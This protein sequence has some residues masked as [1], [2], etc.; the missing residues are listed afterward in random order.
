MEPS[1]AYF[2]RKAWEAAL[3]EDMLGHFAAE[4]APPD[5]PVNQFAVAVLF[6]DLAIFTPLTEAMGDVAAAAVIQLFADMVREEAAFGS[7][8]VVKQIGDE[9]MLV[10]PTA[11][12]ALRF[13]LRLALRAASTP[14]FPSLR[15]GANFG[16]AL[17]R[18]ADYLGATVNI[19]A[20]V[21]AVAQAGELVVTGDFRE[22]V[23]DARVTFEERGPHALKG[24]AEPVE[25]HRLDL[26][27]R[28][29]ERSDPVCGMRLDAAETVLSASSG[30]TRYE[31]CSEACRE[32]FEADPGRYTLTRSP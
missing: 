22:A 3:Q 11:L 1:I 7:G 15:M 13:A 19:A 5:Q 30:G 32:R 2:H 25:L 10:F 16:T 8:R 6:V 12:G 18:E 14:R 21:T 29:G 26:G 24:L 4:V 20:R 28:A 31:F 9:F 27:R 23:A 17:Y